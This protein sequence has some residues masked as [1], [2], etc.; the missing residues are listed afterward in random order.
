MDEGNKR[1]TEEK[2]MKDALEARGWALPSEPVAGCPGDE[3]LDPAFVLESHSRHIS[4]SAS[5]AK[6]NVY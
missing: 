1:Q 4:P 6:F 5:D 3:A 2:M